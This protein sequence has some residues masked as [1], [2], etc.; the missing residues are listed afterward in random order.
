MTE[1][2]FAGFELQQLETQGAHATVRVGGRADGPVLVLLH[3]FPQTHVMW[4]RVARELAPYFRIVLPDLRGYGDSCHAPG[5]SDHA[6]YSKRAMAQD[7]VDVAD[8]LGIDTFV[9]ADYIAR[10]LSGR[11]VDAVAMQAGRIMLTRL[12][13]LAGATQDFA[14]ESTLSS[15][16][17]A[18]FLRQ[19][20]NHGY[21][22]VASSER[23]PVRGR[24]LF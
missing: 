18:S 8:A 10:G 9:N 12:K 15:R 21:S 20:K 17:F 1:D 23:E 14:F 24:L 13:E 5:L 3:G 19:L 6:N 22:L 7:V 2:W 4:H 16:S 11:N